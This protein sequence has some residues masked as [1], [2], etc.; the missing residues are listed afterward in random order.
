MT[1]PCNENVLPRINL[2]SRIKSIQPANTHPRILY[3][4]VYLSEEIFDEFI[5]VNL[6]FMS[7]IDLED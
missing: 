4:R 7:S 2:R 5:V 1:R 6:C 3:M